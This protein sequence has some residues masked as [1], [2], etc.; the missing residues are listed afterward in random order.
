MKVVVDA[1]WDGMAGVWV[2]VARGEVGLVTEAPS[3]EELEGR[4]ALLLPDLLEGREGGP[5]EIEL[6]A[7]RTQ[8]IAA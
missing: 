4:I 7:T 3:I 8:T 6:I 1:R 5:I 2:A